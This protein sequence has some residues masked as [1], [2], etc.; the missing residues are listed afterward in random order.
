MDKCRLGLGIYK[1]HW[2][3]AFGF[4]VEGESSRSQSGGSFSNESIHGSL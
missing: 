4:C 1:S 2:H 3:C